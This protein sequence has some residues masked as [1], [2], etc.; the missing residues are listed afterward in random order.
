MSCRRSWQPL[1]APPPNKMRRPAPDDELAPGE[2]L[3]AK[4]SNCAR[5]QVAA[6]SNLRTMFSLLQLAGRL[7]I[8]HFLIIIIIVLVLGAAREWS[9]CLRF[10][11]GAGQANGVTRTQQVV[12]PGSTFSSLPSCAAGGHLLNSD[13]NRLLVSRWAALLPP[14]DGHERRGGSRVEPPPVGGPSRAPRPRGEP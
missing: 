13:G 14:G 1:V 8:W 6:T 3:A 5:Q 11:R 4:G 9:S 10:R 2:L 12:S 7:L